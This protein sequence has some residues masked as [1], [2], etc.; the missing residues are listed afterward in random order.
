MKMFVHNIITVVI[1]TALY[2]AAFSVTIIE[3]AQ[4]LGLK[5]C[6]ERCSVISGCEEFRFSHL[7]LVC[8][9]PA[10]Q[11]NANIDTKTSQVFNL[12][13]VIY[14]STYVDVYTFYYTCML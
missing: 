6:E 3:L 14:I 9:I 13:K 5:M 1:F 4:N 7:H 10:N 2:G 8:W 11:K 12:S